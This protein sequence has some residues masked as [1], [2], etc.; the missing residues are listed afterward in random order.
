MKYKMELTNINV[1]RSGLIA[2]ITYAILGAI[3]T[4]FGVLA[5]LASEEPA[6]AVAAAIMVGILYCILGFVAGWISALIYN[7]IAHC[8]GGLKIELHLPETNVAE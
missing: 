1:A 6:K 7:A 8:V 5:A 3:V 2:G 4:F